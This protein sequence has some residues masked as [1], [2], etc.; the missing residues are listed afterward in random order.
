MCGLRPTDTSGRN[1]HRRL[2]WLVPVS[3]RFH[4]QPLYGIFVMF[5]REVLLRL[6]AIPVLSMRTQSASAS[7]FSPIPT[8]V[9]ESD[10]SA[11]SD[12]QLKLEFCVIHSRQLLRRET[13]RSQILT[14]AFADAIDEVQRLCLQILERRGL[15]GQEC[16]ALCQACADACVRVSKQ[17]QTSDCRPFEA[18]A[19]VCRRAAGCQ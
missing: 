18:A 4:S 2:F 6:S 14:S 15:H 5:R 10:H 9:A 13:L 7:L 16:P 11:G 17:C 19:A 1:A 8:S 3:S 12:D